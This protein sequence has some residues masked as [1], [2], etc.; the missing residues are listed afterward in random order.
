MKTPLLLAA[1]AA[2]ITLSLTGCTSLR[3]TR[4][5]MTQNKQD[6]ADCR[7]L[8]NVGGVNILNRTA[9]AGGDVVYAPPFGLH[10]SA[11]DCGGKYLPVIQTV[12]STLPSNPN[13]K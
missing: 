3:A 9:D 12:P 5:S 2:L 13:Q 4:V 6:I 10:A 7:F 11:Y 1:V 8:K